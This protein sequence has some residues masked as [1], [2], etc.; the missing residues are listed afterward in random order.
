MVADGCR[1]VRDDERRLAGTGRRRVESE[2]EEVWSIESAY[3]EVHDEICI[4][5][6]SCLMITKKCSVSG[7]YRIR[8][9][10]RWV[11][12]SHTRT[13]ADAEVEMNRTA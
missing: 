10:L 9:N 1:L 5:N 3:Y 6:P 13:V 2:R 12:M 11:F 8:F 7:M 4:V